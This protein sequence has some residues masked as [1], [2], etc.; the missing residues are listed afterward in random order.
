MD[1]NNENVD[2]KYLKTRRLPSLATDVVRTDE[3]HRHTILSAP[4]GALYLPEI[5][6]TGS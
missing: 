1:E 2:R 6:R 3:D 5:E 4:F